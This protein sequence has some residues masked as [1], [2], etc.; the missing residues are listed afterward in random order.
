MPRCTC[1]TNRLYID[2]VSASAVWLIA[3][4]REDAPGIPSKS[5]PVGI[6]LTREDALDFADALRSAALRLPE[7]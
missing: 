5:L 1:C 7:R 2:G 4:R 3:E 6:N